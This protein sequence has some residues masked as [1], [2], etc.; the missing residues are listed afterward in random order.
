MEGKISSLN[1]PSF[2]ISS[3]PSLS[4]LILFITSGMYI[5]TRLDLTCRFA[6]LHNLALLFFAL[7]YVDL[8]V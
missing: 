5:P 3:V 2:Y 8:P 4:C 1:S 6:G 7:L